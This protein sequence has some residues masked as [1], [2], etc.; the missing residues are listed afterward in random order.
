MYGHTAIIYKLS[1]QNHQNNNWLLLLWPPCKKRQAH[2]LTSCM[3][4]FTLQEQ[5]QEQ[6]QGRLHKKEEEE[7]S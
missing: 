7:I 4:E 1:Q 2:Q 5:E 6:E 3:V